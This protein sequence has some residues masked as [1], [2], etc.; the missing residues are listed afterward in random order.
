MN[1]RIAAHIS[2]GPTGCATPD[3]FPA[4]EWRLELVQVPVTDV[5]RA[6]AFYT[7]RAGRL[8]MT[9]HGWLPGEVGYAGGGSRR[10]FVEEVTFDRQ[11]NPQLATA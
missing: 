10:L 2:S 7:D 9:F 3:R 6:K 4:V 5:D 11:G 8:W 1:A